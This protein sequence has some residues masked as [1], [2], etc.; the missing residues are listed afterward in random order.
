MFD[1]D[2]FGAG[3]TLVFLIFHGAAGR[4][5]ESTPDGAAEW[6]LGMLAEAIGGP[7]PTPTAAA[8]TSWADDPYSGGA[9]VGPTADPRRS[10]EQAQRVAG[11]VEQDPHVV[12]RLEVRQDGA[13]GHRPFQ[14]RVEV[15]DPDVQV[16]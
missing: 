15:G 12:L 3:P 2:A 7:C 14:R 6:V 8:L 5:L 1:H 11:R 4:V 13:L 16:L 10:S 9:Y